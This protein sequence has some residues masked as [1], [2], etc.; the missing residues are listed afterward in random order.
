M[1]RDNTLPWHLPDDFKYFK[2]TTIGKP[3]L[4]GRKTFDSL[5]RS[6]PGRLNIVISTQKK[7]PLPEGVLLF[8]DV[9][10]A[11]KRLETEDTDEAF[12]IG[13]A[14]IFEETMQL[15]DRLYI[16]HVHT[17]INDADTFFP[18]T[19]HTHWKLVWEEAHAADEKHQYA[20]TFQ[21]FERVEL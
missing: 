2:K 11:I 14:K 3:V 16:T 19:D 17:V 18:D 7:L 12:I 10:S 13:G 1:G 15:A 20:F 4:M 5:G 21:R 6:L 8:H 9:D